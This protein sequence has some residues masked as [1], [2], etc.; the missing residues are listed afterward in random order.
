MKHRFISPT[1]IFSTTSKAIILVLTIILLSSCSSI[2]VSYDFDTS[3][4]FD[5]YSS[6]SVNSNPPKNLSDPRAEN[7]LISKRFENTITDNLTA[8]GLRKTDKK[9]DLIISYTFSIRPK[10]DLLNLYTQVGFS[11]GSYFRHGG[12][13]ANTCTDISE[14]D[15]GILIVDMHDAQ[16]NSLVWRGTGTDLIPIHMTPEEVTEQV[17]LIVSK[18]LDQYPPR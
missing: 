14:F 4:S 3:T 12:M 2:M 17:E 6:F 16:T 11:Y 5:A 15:Q 1:D 10:I 7:E 18:V 13:G 8:K 9:S